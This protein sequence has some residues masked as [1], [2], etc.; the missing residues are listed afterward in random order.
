MTMFQPVINVLTS[1]GQAE[2]FYSIF[3]A[4]GLGGEILTAIDGDQFQCSAFHYWAQTQLTS[5][6]AISIVHTPAVDYYPGQSTGPSPVMF[7]DNLFNS[8][9]TSGYYVDGGAWQPVAPIPEG[10]PAGRLRTS[11]KMYT[12]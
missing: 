8:V 12:T 1:Y 4:M 10:V 11:T 5:S 7:R 6:S 9:E 2:I 3:Q